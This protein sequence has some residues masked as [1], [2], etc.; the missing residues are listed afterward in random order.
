MTAFTA[1]AIGCVLVALAF[2]L[3]PLLRVPR[4]AT[5]REA[6]NLSIYRDQFAELERDLRMGVIDGV[7][8]DA[9]RAELQRRLLDEAAEE[10]KAPVSPAWRSSR[11]TAVVIALAVPVMAGLLYWK[12]GQPEALDPAR[13]APPPEASNV[14]QE[15]FEAMTQQLADRLKA[16]PEDADGWAMLGRAYKALGRF[17][18]AAKAVAEANQR[19]PG[20]PDLMVEYAEAMAQVHGKLAGEPRRLLEQAIKIAPNDPRALTL[21]GGAAFEAGEYQRAIGYWQTVA[22]AVPADSE[23]GKALAT[24]IQRAQQMAGGA[25]PQ[26]PGSAQAAQQQGAPRVVRGEIRLAAGLK[27]RAGP[28]DTVFIFARAA[29]GPRMPVA[30]LRKQVRDLPASFQLDDSMAM[31]PALKLSALP[32]VVITARIS[33]SG[34][35]MPQSGDL[36]GESAPVAPGGSPIAITIDKV[37]P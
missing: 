14:T 34:G 17:P 3:W 36:Q 22:A 19:S 31:N 20:V 35:A 27:E 23:L 15:Q 29:E 32:R 11:A 24:G 12:L 10:K 30:V 9:A 13:R 33:R 25:G 1:L 18:D 8:Y 2:L 4:A 16:N 28:D 7:Q 5:S 37:V 6:A 21:A 26:A